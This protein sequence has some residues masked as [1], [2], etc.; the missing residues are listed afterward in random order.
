VVNFNA[1]SSNKFNGLGRYSLLDGTG[2]LFGRNREFIGENREFEART[3]LNDFQM[4]FS[5]G[6]GLWTVN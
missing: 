6:T 3:A 4:T 2:K 5:D 1:K